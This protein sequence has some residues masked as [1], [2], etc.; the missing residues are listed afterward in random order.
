M[1]DFVYIGGNLAVRIQRHTSGTW[2]LRQT[3][4]RPGWSWTVVNGGSQMV[5][6][7]PA[8]ASSASIQVTFEEAE[9]MVG[10]APLNPMQRA[11]GLDSRGYLEGQLEV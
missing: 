9:S 8:L 10:R 6:L 1:L 3:T 4:F 7:C 2:K 5:V 11:I